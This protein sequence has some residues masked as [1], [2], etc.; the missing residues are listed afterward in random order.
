MRCVVTAGPT[1][2]PLDQV[3]R[4]TNFSTGR[5][6]AELAVHLARAGHEVVL[7][8]GES[9]TW[10]APAAA[11]V[12]VEPFTT[13]AS[14]GERFQALAGTA[15]DAVFHAAAVSDFAFGPV[16]RRE[17]DGRLTEVRAGKLSTRAGALLAELAPTPKLLD[18]LRGWFPRAWLAGWK[19]EVDGDRA[20]ALAA[21]AEQLAQTGTDLCVVNGP[22]YGDGFG[23]VA[24]HNAPA[25]C[26]DARELLAE[27]AGR[28]VAGPR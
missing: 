5:L 17:P 24:P 1:F 7:L 18:R 4:L 2:E 13:T 9:A 19:Y 23:L 21:G 26:A 15:V 16:W 8:R 10:P 11:S 27:L 6:G 20:S 12:R 28:L 22:A 3:R 14:L 25:H